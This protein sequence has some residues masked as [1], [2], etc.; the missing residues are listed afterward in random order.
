MFSAREE[1]ARQEDGVEYGAHNSVSDSKRIQV[2]D[3]IGILEGDSKLE[4]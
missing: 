2:H 1:P 4:R 3:S